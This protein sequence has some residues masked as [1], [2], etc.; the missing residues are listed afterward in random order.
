MLPTRDGRHKRLY[1]FKGK[2]D[3]NT[4]LKNPDNYEFIYISREKFAGD[5][6]PISI[7]CDC[8]TCQNYSRGYLHHLFRINDTL[9]YRLAAIHNLRVYTEVIDNL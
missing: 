7:D 9:V 1:N 2:L 3:K 6:N 5:K 8:F 4:D